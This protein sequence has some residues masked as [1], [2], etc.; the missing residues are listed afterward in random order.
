MQERS[1]FEVSMRPARVASRRP[2][3]ERPNMPAPTCNAPR[4]ETRAPRPPPGVES[5]CEFTLT[6][7]PFVPHCLRLPRRQQV[8]PG[9]QVYSFHRGSRTQHVA[10]VARLRATAPQ[11]SE[12]SRFR[13]P[14]NSPAEKPDDHRRH[15][16]PAPGS[17]RLHSTQGF[18]THHRA[19]WLPMH[20]THIIEQQAELLAFLGATHPEIKRS[21]LQKWLKH[22]SVL[23]NGQ[24]VTQFNHRLQPGDTVAVRTRQN[25]RKEQLLPRGLQIVFDDSHL[26]IIEKPA[27][28]LSIST[29]RERENTAYAHLTN[30]VRSGIPRGRER[31]WIVHRLD[32]E[33]S[34]LMVFARTEAAKRTLQSNWQATEKRYLAVVEGRL[35]QPEGVLESHLDETGRYQVHSRP[36][37]E[38]TRPALTHYRVLRS[39]RGRSLVELNPLTG[40]RNQ[41]RVHL[42]DAGCPIVGDQKYGAASNP[43][44]RLALHATRLSFLH[45]DSG[46]RLHFESP[47]PHQ[48]ATLV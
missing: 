8:E 2:G 21:K 47:L 1:L 26:I 15:S 23:V 10:E 40:R 4:R 41:I 5:C 29:S 11:F 3:S 46:E 36:A 28:L 33:T 32:R 25:I 27:G 45:P 12:A 7:P 48:L 37:G 17:D 39:H 14:H 6:A 24:P 30:Y 35:P 22:G 20:G 34:G 42:A 18:R 44:R 16:S 19:R 43:A 13:R 9:N 31:V 38:N